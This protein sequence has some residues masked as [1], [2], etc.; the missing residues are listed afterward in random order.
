MNLM[1]CSVLPAAE[2]PG[3]IHGRFHVAGR[4][5]AHVDAFFAQLDEVGLLRQVHG[6][7]VGA[8][9]GRGHHSMDEPVVRGELERDHGGDH[10]GR[11]YHDSEEGQPETVIAA[12]QSCVHSRECPIAYRRATTL[13]LHRLKPLTIW[14]RGY[15]RERRLCTRHDGIGAQQFSRPELDCHRPSMDRPK[16]RIVLEWQTMTPP[17]DAYRAG[18]CWMTEILV[19]NSSGR[20]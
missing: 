13:A 7:H 8:D 12:A 3:F 14:W 5:G 16:G 17:L 19:R 20:S 15:R 1:I 9:P 18:R 10:C 2:F 6:A 4:A 11:R